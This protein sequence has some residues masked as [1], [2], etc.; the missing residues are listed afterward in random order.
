MEADHQG[1][2]SCP[3]NC[4][5]SP[6]LETTLIL[7]HSV[8]NTGSGFPESLPVPLLQPLQEADTAEGEGRVGVVLWT[9]ER[10]NVRKDS[11][12]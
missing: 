11:W 12:H 3:S 6:S 7:P 2:T 1:P 10:L 4:L 8:H 5:Y 9:G